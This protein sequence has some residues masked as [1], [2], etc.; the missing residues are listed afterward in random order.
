MGGGLTNGVGGDNITPTG[1]GGRGRGRGNSPNDTRRPT[2]VHTAAQ[3]P[4]DANRL[5]ASLKATQESYRNILIK[6]CLQSWEESE[7]TIR[8]GPPPI[9]EGLATDNQR[10]TPEQTATTPYEPNQQTFKTNT[11]ARQ[12]QMD[13][14]P[15]ED[16]MANELDAAEGDRTNW[17][18]C[19]SMEN[20]NDSTALNAGLEDFT[21]THQADAHVNPLPAPTPLQHL[22]GRQ[23]EP[24]QG[25]N[26]SPRA[27]GVED[28]QHSPGP[29]KQSRD[30]V[31]DKGKKGRIT[32]IQ[33]G[34]ALVAPTQADRLG[35][36]H[37]SPKTG[38]K[39]ATKET[40]TPPK[41]EAAGNYKPPQEP[42]SEGGMEHSH[43]KEL[44]KSDLLGQAPRR[45]DSSPNALED[46]QQQPLKA[47]RTAR[48]GAQEATTLYET[49]IS[50]TPPAP[51]NEGS[52]DQLPGFNTTHEP[53]EPDGQISD[54]GP[55]ITSFIEFTLAATSERITRREQEISERYHP[56]ST[57]N[58]T[59]QSDC[60]GTSTTEAQGTGRQPAVNSEE[61]VEAEGTEQETGRHEP[62]L[63]KTQT[64]SIEKR[65]RRQARANG[66]GNRGTACFTANTLI[67][68]IKSSR[69]NCFPIW[70]A[71]KGDIVVQ[72]L[73]SGKSEDLS[74]AMMTT[75][76]TVCIFDC[77][78]AKIDLVQVGEAYITAHH[79]IH[80]ENGWMTAR[81]ASNR[82]LGKLWINQACNRVYS[83]SLNQGGNIL[84]NTTAQLPNSPTYLVAA[85]MGCRL[86]PPSAS[87]HKGSLTYP[88]SHL[89]KL[90]QI[91]GMDTGRK[92]FEPNEVTTELNGELCSRN[93]R[94]REKAGPLTQEDNQQRTT[95]GSTFG[96]PHKAPRPSRRP[97]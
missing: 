4:M 94:D 24:L 47:D 91:R 51:A 86:E 6:H 73:S 41:S 92:H 67:L 42:P 27:T 48:K 65:R 95:L 26:T 93:H 85:T 75:I 52:R 45:A 33:L 89:A 83:L 80:T 12:L 37:K 7:I 32:T 76:R 88:H 63:A 49:S 5:N 2:S 31:R 54:T 79:H 3:D 62:P 43:R 13:D 77:P 34:L 22:K 36:K 16:V 87:Q 35:K 28:N 69:A 61:T 23:N 40:N 25:Q 71:V 8:H 56:H 78:E 96:F 39:G 11:A 21:P 68:V 59:D 82:G 18:K 1:R 57:K 15:K 44:G 97:I 74:M 17:L 64:A 20:T 66:L 30:A 46:C 29:R 81:Q 19:N 60:N 58:L 14:T 70:T 38:V 10:E 72:S 84:V 53:D 55:A 50:H 90:E 9:S